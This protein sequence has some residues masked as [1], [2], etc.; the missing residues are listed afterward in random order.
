M[1]PSSQQEQRYRLTASNVAAYFKPRCD[2]NFRWNTV[3]AVS[4]MKPGIGWNVPRRRHEHSRPG[5]RL[6]MDEGDKFEVGN[7]ESYV[8]AYGEA[9]V[10][11]EGIEEDGGRRK[12]KDLK[13]ERFVEAFAAAP[14]PRFV[15]QLEVILTPEQEAG[16]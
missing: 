7:V 3:E 5:I 4:R 8:E 1:K 16:L 6:L 12:V 14:F 15:A 13:F 10:L 2:R 9:A 11:T